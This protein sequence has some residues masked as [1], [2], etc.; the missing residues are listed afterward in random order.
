[1]NYEAYQAQADLTVPW[2]L[3][4]RTALALLAPFEAALGESMELRRAVAACELLA[5][6]TLSHERP[7]YG[8]ATVMVECREV[9][10]VEEVAHATP[11]CSLL[12][13]RK[14]MATTHPRVLVVAPLSGHFATLLRG[15]L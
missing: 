9:A 3:A 8:I 2:R 7:A 4:A 13:F 5:R 14:N 1:M 11:F 10:V 15:T 12:H 6:A